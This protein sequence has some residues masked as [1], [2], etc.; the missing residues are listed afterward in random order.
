MTIYI[1]KQNHYKFNYLLN[2]QNPDTGAMMGDWFT[3]LKEIE[4]YTRHWVKKTVKVNF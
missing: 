4:E 3:S 1:T 2:W